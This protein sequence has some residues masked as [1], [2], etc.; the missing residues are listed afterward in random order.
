MR[1]DKL[2]RLLEVVSQE[3]SDGFKE[4]VV[5]VEKEVFATKKSV[6]RTEFYQAARSEIK[7]EILFEVWAGEYQN[8]SHLE[9]EG[10]R[11][12]IIKTYE[13]DSKNLEL[14]CSSY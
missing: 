9:F 8:E 3:D 13:V 12:K 1:K 7:P 6:T 5:L 14:T 10:K 11:Y 4:D 2:V